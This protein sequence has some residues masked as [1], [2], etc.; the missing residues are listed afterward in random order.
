MKGNTA[1]HNVY[2]AYKQADTLNSL[3]RQAIRLYPH[4]PYTSR[5]TV[6]SLRRGWLIAISRLGENWILHPCHRAQRGAISG[7]MAVFIL[8]VFATI[9]LVLGVI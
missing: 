2:S 7:D 1:S 8:S 9:L 6:N 5:T 4:R 3:V